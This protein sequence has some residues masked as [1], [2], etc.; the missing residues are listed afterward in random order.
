VPWLQNARYVKSKPGVYVLYDNKL[1]AI[2]IGESDN[3]KKE[4]L[5]YIA[6]AVKKNVMIF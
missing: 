4:F 1:N 3:L 6:K 2:Y 5:K